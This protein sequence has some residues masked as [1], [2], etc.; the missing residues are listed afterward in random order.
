MG[1]ASYVGQRFGRLL[2]ISQNG[3]R[4]SCECSCGKSHVIQAGNRLR[5][6]SCGCLHSAQLSAR[7]KVHGRSKTRAYSIW[8]QMKAR[9]KN[10]KLPCFPDYG[11]R[12][13][14]VCDRWIE[15]F[16]SF[17]SDMG[18]PPSPSH[19]IDR[20]DNNG[21]YEPRNCRWATRRVQNQNTSRVKI[22]FSIAEKIR[23]MNGLK[24]KHS[25]I[26]K[27]LGVSRN[28]VVGVVHLN[29]WSK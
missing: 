17:I 8:K 28:T 23:E 24:M 7:N 12:G 29:A 20:K 11:G 1:K 21:N 25:Q 6:K 5:I 19:T 9:C 14:R 26:A 3:P 27:A 10:H 2:V 13:I 16:E 15:S 18:E 4:L 22:N